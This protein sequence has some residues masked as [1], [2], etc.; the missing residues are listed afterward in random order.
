MFDRALYDR[1]DKP[2]DRL[3]TESLKW[4]AR[5]DFGN[6]DAIPMWVADMDFA[7]V[8]EVIEGL[9]RRAAHGAFGYNISNPRDRQALINWMARRHALE[10]TTDDIMFC[11]GVVDAIYHCLKALFPSGGKVIVQSPVYGPFYSMVEK[12][13]MELIEN[14]LKRVENVWR[15]D[16]EGLEAILKAGAD[17]LLMCS[18]HNPVGRIWTEDELKT[19][20]GLCAR[21]N[22]R[23]ICDEIHADFE[24]P[25]FKH[26]CI[27]S[28]P[29]AQN[30]VQLVSATKTF[31]LAALRHSAIICKDADARKKI[32]ARLGEVMADVNLYGMLATR[33]AYEN[34]DNWL[35][36]LL[37]YLSENRDVFEKAL[38]ET[39]RLLPAHVEGTY[40]MWVD[41]GQLGLK[42]DELN[43]FFIKTAGVIP[44]SGSFFGKSS[45]SFIRLNIA[46]QRSN[47]LAAADRITSAIKAL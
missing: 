35:D 43:S 1:F 2:F 13:G 25:G 9:T 15:M 21:Y 28:F 29:E 20:T 26:R 3:G 42:G 39:G 18:P 30:A 23:I 5:K 19:V 6:A 33:L 41:C 7:T 36:T 17:A 14:P 44:N 47:I 46:T 27:L 37:V 12:A 4:D 31:N 11:P 22:A 10:I 34:G 32:S 45:D 40:L 8:P 16:F 24:M 38:R